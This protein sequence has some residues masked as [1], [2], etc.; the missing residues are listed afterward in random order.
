M[1]W[2]IFG[3]DCDQGATSST[4]MLT[5][6]VALPSEV[7]AVTVYV[8]VAVTFDGV[9]LIVPEP[10]SRFKPAGSGGVTL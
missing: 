2:S 9:P 8:S 3:I 7:D 6:P 10:L 5:V 4:V 1:V